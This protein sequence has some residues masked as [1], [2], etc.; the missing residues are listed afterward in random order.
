MSTTKRIFSS[1]GA[2]MLTICAIVTGNAINCPKILTA[3]RPLW[4]LEYFN[5]HKAGIEQAF[6]SVL[7]SN[8]VTDQRQATEVIAEVI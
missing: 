7:G 1:S 2:D 6:N 4:T 5:T 3:N 8:S